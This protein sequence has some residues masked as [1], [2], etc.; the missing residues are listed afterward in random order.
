MEQI[1]KFYVLINDKK[2]I[3]MN[4]VK[5]VLSFDE[6]YVSLEAEQGKVSVEG[7]NLRIE[8]LAKESG[9]IY[10]TGDILGV[11]F[12]EEKPVEGVFKRLFK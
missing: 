1:G 7:R 2:S 10:I 3:T 12:S 5:N 4:G 8:S 6:G 9:E 11:I